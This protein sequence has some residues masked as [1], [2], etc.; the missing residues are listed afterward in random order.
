MLMSGFG[1]PLFTAMPTRAW[2]KSTRVLAMSLPSFVSASMLSGVV[3]TTS[4]GDPSLTLIISV[5]AGKSVIVTLWP[6]A[7][8]NIGISSSSG[9]RI[10]VEPSSV[11]S[12]ACTAVLIMSALSAPSNVVAIF[13]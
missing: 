5:A 2:T 7:F 6:V 3:I 1:A 9:S 13:L 8:S 12:A 4:E 11:I 10:A